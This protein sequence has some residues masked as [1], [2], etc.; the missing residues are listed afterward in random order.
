MAVI[1]SLVADEPKSGGA[2]T[3]KMKIDRI[4]RISQDFA[5]LVES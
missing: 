4:H 3:F 2:L 1:V 5:I